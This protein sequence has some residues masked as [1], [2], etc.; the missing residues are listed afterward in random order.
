[1]GVLPNAK[2]SSRPV[3]VGALDRAGEAIDYL[4]L[5]SRRAY[6]AAVPICAAHICGPCFAIDVA[7][8]ERDPLAGAQPGCGGEE[9]ERP[10]VRSGVRGRVLR[11][12]PMTR[13]AVSRC[14]GVGGCRCRVAG[15][16]D[17]DPA[18]GRALGPAVDA[19]T[20]V[21]ATC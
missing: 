14:S 3:E 20:L 16:G 4:Y 13:L 6:D 8:L 17:Y 12:L 2:C 18:F 7:L 15:H 19:E 11:V 5:V 21:A 1:M 10:V 9:H